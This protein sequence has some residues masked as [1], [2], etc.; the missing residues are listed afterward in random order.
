MHY[1][2]TISRQKLINF[3]LPNRISFRT[4]NVK[5]TPHHW[6]IARTFAAGILYSESPGYIIHVLLADA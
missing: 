2:Y 1:E 3:P 6:D 5:M 4:P